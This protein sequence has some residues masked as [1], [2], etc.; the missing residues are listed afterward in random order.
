MHLT[1]KITVSGRVQGVGFRP[2]I[3]SNA[4]KHK[5]NG[6]VQNNMN[7][8]FIVA[9][10][11]KENLDKFLYAIKSEPPRLSRIDEILVNEIESSLFL[12]FTIIPSERTGKSSLV[13]PVDS[14]ICPDCIREMKDTENFRYQ[15]PFINCTQCGPRYTIIEELPYDRPYTVMKDFNM[16][17]KCAD[18]YENPLNRRHHAQPIA[19]DSCGP[20]LILMSMEGKKIA[21]KN[22][23]IN[24]VK[25]FLSEGS[26]V[27]IKGLGGYHLA[28]DAHNEIAINNLRKR[29]KRLSR[30]LAVMA[31][32]MEIVKKICHVN[33]DEKDILNSPE[34]PIVVLKQI[35]NN[36][37]PNLL[38]PNM[39][40]LGVM[41]P[42]TPIHY[43]LFDDNILDLLVMTSANPSGLPILY[44]DEQALTYLDGIADYILTT[45]R[46]ILHPLDDS[47]LQI[48]NNSFSLFRRSR[49]F[50]PDPIKTT[51]NVHEIVAL[52]GQ[53]KNV[54]SL[55]RH[56]QIFLGP[57]IGDLDNIEVKEFFKSEYNH[58]MK[59]MGTKNKIIAIDKHPL[60]ATREIAEEL[61]G[62]IVEI[63]HH[64][65]HLV[66]CMEDNN[67]NEPS[68]GIILDGTGYGEDGN[69]WGFE[70]LYG[71][72]KSYK[73][74]AH[75]KYTPLPGNEK[76]IKEPWR[77]AVGM[78]IG[79]LGDE[80]KT[81]SKKIFMDKEYEIDIIDNMIKRNINSP[82][83]GTCGRLFDA[84][85]AI[86]SVCNNATYDG[87]PAILLSEMMYN[88][89][90]I[91]SHYMY[92]I[93][94][95]D[96]NQLELN[97]ST[98]MLGIID[99]YF[100]GNETVDIVQMFHNTIIDACAELI[101]IISKEHSDFSNNVMLSGGSFLNKYL[102]EEL[103]DKL[104][105]RGFKV[106]TH[107]KV[108]CS[109]GGIAFGQIIIA[110]NNLK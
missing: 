96:V 75:L 88:T 78:L 94:K 43:L 99:D 82:L 17:E 105:S 107:Q 56:N 49:G 101:C 73:R 5:I 7:G 54:F 1:L 72:A 109:D 76:A 51:Q 41:M 12:D 37:L 95:D 38:A 40:T 32:N 103:E 90:D 93:I 8:V 26:I 58:L 6:T 59:W 91:T 16:C 85:S 57:H 39:N 62:E 31:S 71:N 48:N 47:V 80:G 44:K 64:H 11:E 36:G 9:Q 106:F 89:N 63:Q 108:P 27:A 22:N 86:L 77:N 45:N 28:C 104:K 19:C 87:E 35:L 30:P 55:G 24:R 2:F 79:Y 29:K 23:A 52:G 13:I 34:A 65:A 70:V 69:I 50:V 83:A 18:E 84:I 10:A 92:D 25:R 97:L 110:A 14:A 60:Y 100:S 74:M 102:I 61:D 3:F 53:Q 98:T 15:Y 46:E 66:S 81:L 67:V 33:I 42:Y 4:K 20:E 21:N 68:F